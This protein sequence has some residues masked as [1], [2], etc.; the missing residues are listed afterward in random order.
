M[1]WKPI[2]FMLA[3]VFLFTTANVCV[4]EIKYLPTV[5]LVFMRSLIS[6]AICASYVVTLKSPFLGINKKWLYIRGLMGMVALSLFFYTI[7]HIPLASATTI[8]YLS[9]VFTVILAMLFLG[10]KVK[11]IQWLFLSIAI[12]GIIMVKGFDPRVPFSFLII[13]VCS[14]FLAAVAY[15]ATMKCKNTDHPVTIVMY[16]HL[17]AVPVMGIILLPEWGSVQLLNS[18]ML[19]FPKWISIGWYEWGMGAVIGV[20]SVLAQI[21]MAY[22]IHAEDASIVTPIKYFGAIIALAIGYFHFNESLST[23]SIIG[24]MLVIAGVTLNTFVKRK[25][26]Q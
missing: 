5:Q 17:I 2:L 24:I 10:Q 8:Q 14:A 23:T 15:F 6:L 12:A 3:S 19:D 1:K 7:Q 20:F 21:L 9:P 16:F 4:K 22:A 11:T 18:A 26:I 25:S 13:G